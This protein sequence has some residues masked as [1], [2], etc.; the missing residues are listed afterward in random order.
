LV[1]ADATKKRTAAKYNSS[2]RLVESF[3]G[4][5]QVQMITGYTM[6]GG[7]SSQVMLKENSRKFFNKRMFLDKAGIPMSSKT[8]IDLSYSEQNT[9]VDLRKR[10]SREELSNILAQPKA[11]YT[12]L[13]PNKI[14][15]II[16]KNAD[17]QNSYHD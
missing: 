17:F 2:Q 12:R 7:G 14:Q 8:N 10:P 16:R 11:N 5:D 9:S 15:N 6:R 4:K 1:A 3:F 13:N